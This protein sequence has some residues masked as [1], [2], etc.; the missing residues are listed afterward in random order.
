MTANDELA[1]RYHWLRSEAETVADMGQRVVEVL[2][3][4]P[5]DTMYAA[6]KMRAALRA[7]IQALTFAGADE[8]ED[9]LDIAREAHQEASEA[10]RRAES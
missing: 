9:L 7:T 3:R 2:A 5:T 10:L 8:I 4:Q 1:A 6:N